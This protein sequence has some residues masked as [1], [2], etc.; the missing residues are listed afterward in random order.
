M[1]FWNTNEMH[2][3]QDLV[4]IEGAINKNNDLLVKGAQ[5]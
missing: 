2:V 3:S 5:A 4:P 1:N